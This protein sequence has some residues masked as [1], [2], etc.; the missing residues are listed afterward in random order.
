MAEPVTVRE[1]S[2]GV[3]RRTGRG[4][5]VR[6]L[7]VGG[8]LLRYA[9]LLIVSAI[10]VVPV[11]YAVLGGFRDAPQLAADPVGRLYHDEAPSGRR[12][13]PRRRDARGAG[14]D[15]DHLGFARR[16]RSAKRARRK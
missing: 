6:A 3:E 7:G 9:L 11:A 13:P 4:A 14:P 1:A 12:D 16:G 5:G 2:T 8:S 15:D 10:V